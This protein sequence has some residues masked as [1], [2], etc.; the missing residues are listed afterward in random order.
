[1]KKLNQNSVRSIISVALFSAGALFCQKTAAGDF[2][3]TINAVA[4]KIVIIKCTTFK[5]DQCSGSG[6]IAKMDDKTYI[7][8]NQHVI[9]GCPK[10]SFRTTTGEVLN[11][12]SVE[13]SLNR[14]IV[15]LQIEDRDGFV[16]SATPAI[17]IPIAIFGNSEGG[18]VATE[19]YGETTG[20]TAD[21][22]EVSA[23]FVSGNS[24]SPVLNEQKEVIGIAS[25]VRFNSKEDD[26]K[27]DVRRFCYRL[28]GDKW[29]PVNWKQY[30]EKYGKSYIET[31]E[32]VES[33]FK[34]VYGWGNDPYGYVPSDF[35]NYDLRKWA[36]EHNNMVD[37]INE[38]VKTGRATTKELNSIN[39]EISNDIYDSAQALALF[40]QRKSD[41][42]DIKLNS[43]DLTGFLRSK[44]ED[45]A[46]SLN[47]ASKEI[48]EF[49]KE[50]RQ[51]D[52]FH[53]K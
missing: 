12:R 38:L 21:L 50:L 11:P 48:D 53:F 45:Y 1:M 40:C 4:D 2:P 41:Q 16:V 26:D 31:S 10:V 13:L 47:W 6:F 46:S 14:D 7:F 32:M 42:V 44:F 27:E 22:V 24:G 35:I 52:Y 51:S 33:V 34:I 15:R 37:H 29:V 3:Y 19:L 36:K 43:R 28:T 49:G 17:D 30:N 8:T 25:F 39:K 5:D 20:V 18:G 9:L 23:E